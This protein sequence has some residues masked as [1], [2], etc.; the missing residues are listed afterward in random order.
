MR[1]G[2]AASAAILLL[3]AAGCHSTGTPRV[4]SIPTTRDYQE[5]PPASLAEASR[6]VA[7]ARKAGAAHTAPYEYYSAEEYLETAR[8]A[9]GDG[10]RDY[11][12]L[13]QRMAEAALRKE[14]SL[15]DATPLPD[16]SKEDGVRTAFTDLEARLRELDK[17]KSIAVAPV[18]Y[19]RATAGLS[20]AE[21]LLTQR[22]GWKAVAGILPGVSA[23]IDTIRWQDSDGDGVAD[24]KDGAP[25]EAEDKDGFEDEDG[26]PDLDNDRDGIPD[27]VD[28][29]PM[30]AETRNRWRDEDGAADDYPKLEPVFFA[31]G[32]TALSPDARGYLR[33][34]KVIL[35][36]APELKLHIKGFSD[37]L[38]SDT[39]S[40]DLSHR[41]AQEVQRF[42]MILGIT[43]DRLVSTF[44]GQAEAAVANA[45]NRVELAFE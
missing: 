16:L 19:A 18:L 17:D 30:T 31:E 39:Y 3:A 15:T 25:L 29:E 36:E 37:A 20:R 41:R 12:A 34:I 2:V 27:T 40:M 13:A 8:S 35:D 6:A 23:D 22:K 32:S 1:K 33:G 28:R 43:G 5:L 7:E 11:A 4:L 21:Y 26:A 44:H 10:E 45:G 42:L 9:K 24:L 14:P 38:H